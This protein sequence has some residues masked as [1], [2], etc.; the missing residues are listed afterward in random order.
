MEAQL[1]WNAL[2]R[3]WWLI[4]LGP[5]LAAAAAFFYS[6]TLTP[7]YQTSSTLLVNQTQV[8]GSI[9]YNDVLTSERLTNTYAA[10]LQQQR[11]YL[12]SVI[13]QLD[14]K[15][16][17]AQLAAKVHIS[18]VPNTQLLRITVED[19][20]P[21]RAASIA[22][23][24]G[25]AFVNENATE[26]GDRNNISLAVTAPIPGAPA[27][28]NI[29][30][31]TLLA[32]I[33]GLMV[34][35]GVAVLIEYLDD[36]VKAEDQTEE[37]FGLPTLGHVRR[38][39]HGKDDEAP[40]STREGVEAFAQL[41]TNIHFAGL[42]KP[43]KRLVVTGSMPGE[44]KST[45]AAGL[46]IALSQ[47]GQRVILVDSD[48]RRPTLHKVFKVSNSYGI[49]GLLLS[50]AEDPKNALMVTPYSNLLLLPSGPIPA[51][52]SDLL[53]S[54]NWQHLVDKLAELAHYVIFDTPPTLSVS[55]ASVLAGR[56]DGTILV[57]E[58][59]RTR[60]NAV[61][62]ALATLEH[63]NS[64]V[65]GIVKNKIRSRKAGYYYYYEYNSQ[66]EKNQRSGLTPARVVVPS[67]PPEQV[68]PSTNGHNGNGN[69]N[70][71]SAPVH[72]SEEEKVA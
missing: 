69:G 29:M 17:E 45:T 35:A 7:Q 24:L 12:T 61:R 72:G 8:G 5:I 46:A 14:L 11:G 44:G 68:Q 71:H 47:A 28:P 67:D 63:T 54:P 19:P 3:S 49:T 38:F 50:R 13:G 64:H 2:R 58:T 48:L 57:T 70:G 34:V 39:P 27:S 43:L 22:N 30:Q 37:Y 25:D 9:Q 6:H 20:S 56:A 52:P 36:T 18:A 42:N 23:T 33:L 26:L 4:L 1:Y 66:A 59:G 55:D 21:E 65:V 32:A 16:T 60:R 51:N 41:R 40:L 31:N 15:M 10:L 62:E 53:M